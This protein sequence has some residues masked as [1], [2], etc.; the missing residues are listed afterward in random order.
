MRTRRLLVTA[1]AGLALAGSLAGCAGSSAP[2]A[3]TDTPTV[4]TTPTKSPTPTA[5]SAAPVTPANI[6]SSCDALGTGT[7]RADAVGDLRLQGDGEG[8]VRPA[9]SG[10]KLA[11]GCD[12]IVGDTTGILVLISTASPDA[13]TAAAAALPAQGYT[14]GA[15]EDFGATFCSME[16]SG[17]NTEEMIVA[18]ESTWIYMSTSN[19]NGRA[20]LSNIA[21]QIWG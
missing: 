8:F 1:I 10:A 6:P 20:Y 4:T 3:S 13:V 12:W 11:L 18:R 9:P 5:T 7:D 21:S 14:C 17:E 2:A 16:G 19:R 15:S